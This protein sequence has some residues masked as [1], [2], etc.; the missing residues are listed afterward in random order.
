MDFTS[1]SIKI[2]HTNSEKDDLPASPVLMVATVD[3]ILRFYTLSHVTKASARLVQ[4]PRPV[5]DISPDLLA[6]HVTS[7][8]AQVA[9][10]SYTEGQLG[11]AAATGLPADDDFGDDESDDDP[12]TPTE[13][14]TTNSFANSTVLETSAAVT[15]GNQLN[16]A[17][18]GSHGGHGH[19][20]APV[21][22]SQGSARQQFG[23]NTSVPETPDNLAAASD[24]SIADAIAADKDKAAATALPDDD[25]E[26]DEDAAPALPPP[27]VTA[28]ET[29]QS[30]HVAQSY[31]DFSTAP[32]GINAAASKLAPASS[33]NSPAAPA[34]A[35]ETVPAVAAAAS[36]A[37]GSS[38][39][40]SDAGRQESEE[41]RALHEP[42]LTNT[43][44]GAL[45]EKLTAEAAA[46]QLPAGSDDDEVESEGSTS[47]QITLP[48]GVDPVISH[49]ASEDGSEASTSASPANL[50]R[51]DIAPTPAGFLDE[52]AGKTTA[53]PDR[54]GQL[55]A[56]GSSPDRA[57]PDRKDQSPAAERAASME[58][59]LTIP[60]MVSGVTASGL[61]ASDPRSTKATTV[62]SM[63]GLDGKLV[64]NSMASSA[65]PVSTPALP[66]ISTTTP[67]SSMPASG[68]GFPGLTSSSVES[69]A[70]STTSIFGQ[71]SGQ[72]DPHP[73]SD[74]TS[75]KS[76][77][78][79]SG[80]RSSGGFQSF[81]SNAG[82]M[83]SFGQ[84]A[85]SGGSMPAFGLPASGSSFGQTSAAALPASTQFSAQAGSLQS[86][87]QPS[88]AAPSHGQSS[89]AGQP[90]FP[91]PFTQPG[92]M[93][94]F[95]QPSTA[96]SMGKPDASAPM[97]SLG[98]TGAF[99]GFGG[100]ALVPPEPAPSP[101][102]SIG[103]AGAFPSFGGS[104]LVPSKTAPAPLSSTG[105]TGAFPSFGGSTPV[106]PKIAQ[107]EAPKQQSMGITGP[108]S[109]PP[110]HQQ[111][112]FRPA[113]Q[114][115]PTSPPPVSDF[116]R[117]TRGSRTA[118]PVFSG[119]GPQAAAPLQGHAASKASHDASIQ[120]RTGQPSR[121]VHMTG[122]ETM[123][124]GSEK[125]LPHGSSHGPYPPKAPRS[126]PAVRA[127]EPRLQ[128]TCAAF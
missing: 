30:T 121:G 100:S 72:M 11:Q 48:P 80:A 43:G 77:F 33:M 81:S 67:Q 112:P 125:S 14:T 22:E 103:H 36:S 118:R 49:D 84:I 17:P 64:P 123:Q 25:F 89:A 94:S 110:T 111:A 82:G 99:S 104:A 68:G 47:A 2:P 57:D 56:V 4:P 105:H 41:S 52:S 128:G 38:G 106:T 58:S 119:P 74:S 18:A 24:E 102:S 75:T 78:G 16:A 7:Q 108:Q 95:G 32:P 92:M 21:A 116:P 115:A 10:G 1:T 93:P 34:A 90:S 35:K 6:P 23:S 83:S 59:S 124:Q 62:L 79:Q 127:P 29:R 55:T 66:Q 114:S 60:P 98:S 46:A 117:E 28:S 120:Q 39:R 63:T 12:Q 122:S 50:A 109:P 42:L 73:A 51:R 70:A 97:P 27:E 31:A 107:A 3:G 19:G 126:V 71:P 61:N 101:V 96:N 9:A 88:T 69:Q 26:D 44:V 113:N 87:G 37:A 5:P 76:I 20:I 45:S 86:F 53:R 8:A 91:Q 65:A 15:A 85:A 40:I 54:T 13:Q